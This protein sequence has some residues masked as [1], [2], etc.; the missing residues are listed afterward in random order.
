MNLP[1]GE[2]L[3]SYTHQIRCRYGETDKMGY[4]YYGRY[5]EYFEVARTEMIRAAGFSYRSLEESGV[6]LPVVHSEIQYKEPVFYD[7]LMDI[8]VHVYEMP[9]VRLNTYYEVHTENKTRLHTLGSVQL[10]FANM[11]TRRPMR[12]PESFLNGI[13]SLKR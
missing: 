3:I 10:V 4:V 7:E 9:S 2:P 8:T 11:E 12:A 5:L 1:S 6:M 13:L